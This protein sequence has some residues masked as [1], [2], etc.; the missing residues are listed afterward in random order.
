MA[1]NFVNDAKKAF[2][3]GELL[4]ADTYKIALYTGAV[5]AASGMP[6]YTAT[7]EVSG[8]GYSAGGATLAG[9]S[10]SLQSGV[11][12]LDFTTPTWASATI[13]ATYA[14]IYDNT[15]AVGPK[16]AIA[17]LDFGGTITSTNGTFTVTMPGSGSGTSIIRIQ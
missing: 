13:A 8:T 5:P 11:G 3:K 16:R 14:V 4:A 7:N 9:Y 2:L 15:D 17:I 12:T 1:S 10:A 6:A